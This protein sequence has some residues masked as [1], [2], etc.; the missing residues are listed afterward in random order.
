LGFFPFTLSQNPYAAPYTTPFCEDFNEEMVCVT[1]TLATTTPTNVESCGGNS[2][3]PAPTTTG[4]SPIPTTGSIC[5]N[6]V[7]EAFEECD[8]GTVNV[9]VSG[10]TLTPPLSGSY[11]PTTTNSPSGAKAGNGASNNTCS[12]TCRCATQTS[13]ENIGDGSGWHCQ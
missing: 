13:Y 1:G 12:T 5:G 8:N 6:G 2:T 4:L 7:K 11:L 10:T 3:I 9:T